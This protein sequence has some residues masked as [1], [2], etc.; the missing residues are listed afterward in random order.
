MVIIFP[1]CLFPSSYGF[2]MVK[3]Y[4]VRGISI[5]NRQYL[6]IALGKTWHTGGERVQ[7]KVQVISKYILYPPGKIYLFG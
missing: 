1:K 2:G 7:K 5:D 4:H 3:N 6:S